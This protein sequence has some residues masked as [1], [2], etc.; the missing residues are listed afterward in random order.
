MAERLGQ[1][2][3]SD[4]EILR[5]IIEAA[6]IS[7][8]DTVI[9]IGPGKGI[10]T[11]ALCERAGKVIAIELDSY[12]S[13]TLRP[14]VGPFTNLEIINADALKTLNEPT[15][16]TTLQKEESRLKLV[17]NIPYQITT[18]LLFTLI[19]SPLYWHLLVLLIQKEVAKKLLAKADSSERTLITVLTN[20]W[21]ES[22][23][24]SPVPK[25]AF[26]PQPKVDGAIISLKPKKPRPAVL[27]EKEFLRLLKIAFSAKRKTLANVLSAGYR[28]EKGQIKSLLE[29][30]RLDPN[31]RAED[32]EEKDWLLLYNSLKSS[33]FI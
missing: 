11:R 27:C 21:A 31:L 25:T 20:L 15:L 30:S 1:H 13:K 6:Q 17:S 12:L 29:K 24:I 32:L 4:K 26:K 3:L 28:K 7:K 2:F 10:L 33:S 8:K 9:E 14:A 22:N 19:F 23:F 5:K 18:P 16:L